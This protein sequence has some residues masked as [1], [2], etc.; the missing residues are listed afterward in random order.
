[1]TEAVTSL[2][3][4]ASLEVHTWVRFILL[5]RVSTA[6]PAE[7]KTPCSGEWN[8]VCVCS[9]ERVSAFVDIFL[10]PPASPCD[11][12]WYCLA[13]LSWGSQTQISILV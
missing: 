4:A 2:K 13:M 8:R 1:M 10:T 11:L 3:V 12:L 7:L 5:S 9:D 6:M